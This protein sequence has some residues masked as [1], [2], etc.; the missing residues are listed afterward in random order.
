MTSDTESGRLVAHVAS[1]ARRATIL[2]A[3]SLPPVT[4]ESGDLDGDQLTEN[5]DEERDD[6]QYIAGSR[7]FTKEESR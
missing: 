3:E 6:S 4:P 1:M 2:N 7:D 5:L